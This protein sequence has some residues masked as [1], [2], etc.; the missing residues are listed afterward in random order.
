M[1]TNENKNVIIKKIIQKEGN[2]KMEKTEKQTGYRARPVA[3]NVKTSYAEREIIKKTIVEIKK[4]N[5]FKSETDA[6]LFLVN[7]YEKTKKKD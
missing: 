1:L 6:L 4:A 2:K 3:Y 5:E 7:Y